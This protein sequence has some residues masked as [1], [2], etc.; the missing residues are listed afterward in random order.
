MESQNTIDLFTVLKTAW[1]GRKTIVWITIVFVVLGVVIA[2]TTPRSY[3]VTTVMVP[4]MQS[5]SSSLGNLGGLEGLASMAG[6]NLSGMTQSPEDISPLVYPEIVKSYD[7]VKDV[8]NHK[9]NW[10][11]LEEPVS[12]VQYVDE[13]GKPGLFNRLKKGIMELPGKVSA[14]IQKTP[15]V[16]TV[17]TE[18]DLTRITN[19]EKEMWDDLNRQIS[20]SV[21][22]KN[23]YV[24]MVVNGPEPLATAQIAD[25]AQKLLQEKITEYRIVKSQQNLEFI[26]GR[27]N[28]K[29]KEF[30]NAQEALA[31]YLDENQGMTSNRAKTEEE[32]LQSEYDL[33]LTVYTELAKQLETAKIAVKED[34]PIFSIIQSVI[35]PVKPSKPRKMVIL[36]LSILIG[37]AL[38]VG[39]VFAK[40]HWSEVE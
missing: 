30:E 39:T 16:P 35:V 18:D 10:S 2:F 37:G 9:Y 27:F 7:F 24:T 19:A 14:L 28:E 38:G 13:Q 34:T 5:R 23:G 1:K 12:L 40:K 6:I 11:G 20:L 26:E 25:K 33:T 22:K 4:Q 31:R 36:M 21:D 17:K 8:M 32:R 3:S 29:K 15:E